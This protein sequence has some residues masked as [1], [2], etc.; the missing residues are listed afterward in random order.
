METAPLAGATGA[1]IIR[2]LPNAGAELGRDEFLRILVT[3]LRHQDPLSP[4]DG[5]QFASELAQFSS[6]EQLINLNDGL[7]AQAQRD[8]LLSFTTNTALATGLIGRTATAPGNFVELTGSGRVEVTVDIEGLGGVATVELRGPSG[9]VVATHNL[10]TVRGG[11][12]VLGW[13]SAA[14]GASLPPGIYEYEITVRATDGSSPTV[15]P[16]VTALIDGLEF[17]NGEVVLRAGS[18][19]IPL[20]AIVEIG[21][22]Q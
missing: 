18:L 14:G 21:S 9:A 17:R 15:K 19:R 1:A 11:R 3:Q 4:L 16:F 8:A 2:S 22:A 5:S 6:L 7:E 10:G 13:D 12:Q 20:S